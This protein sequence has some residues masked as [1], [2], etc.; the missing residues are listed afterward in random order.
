MYLLRQV[1]G[2]SEVLRA[3]Q[4]STATAQGCLLMAQVKTA[5]AQVREWKWNLVRSRL[6]YPI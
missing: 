6:V 2:C 3:A 4:D 5:S 1:S